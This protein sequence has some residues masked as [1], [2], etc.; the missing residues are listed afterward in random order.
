MLNIKNLNLNNKKIL[1]R[2]DFNVPITAGEITDFYRITECIPTIKYAL[3]KNAAI[4]LISHLGEPQQITTPAEQKLLSLQILVPILEKLLNTSVKFLSNWY[5]Q[6]TI[7]VLPGEIVLCENVRFIPEEQQNDTNF[8]KRLA[9]LA[10]CIVMDAF[11][12]AH[13]MHASTYG[14]LNYATIAVAGLL[15][16]K[17]I[18]LLQQALLTP[19]KPLAA[20]V[21]GCKIATKVPMLSSLLQCADQVAVGGAIATTCL[22]AAGYN[23]GK[24]LIDLEY[25][26]NAT[27]LNGLI[28]PQDVIVLDE[29]QQI[30]NKDINSISNNDCI[31]DIGPKTIAQYQQIIEHANTIIWNG[32]M[33]KLED[34]RFN[35][36]TLELANSIANS[37]CFS[38]IGGG[39]TL[40]I[41]RHVDL[42]NFSHRSTGGGAFLEFIGQQTLPMLELLKQYG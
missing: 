4:I 23:T 2:T 8:S 26:N 38:I 33:G 17:E 10:D 7:N 12:T 25:I 3:N 32:P 19:S 16:Y 15:L 37:S 28:L 42:S 11:A 13:R 22:A 39:D 24:S 27:H 30:L 34:P 31:L 40:A 14:I 21:G 29:Q 36:G 9:N 41:S 1:I 5:S 35:H 6:D 20:F 18:S